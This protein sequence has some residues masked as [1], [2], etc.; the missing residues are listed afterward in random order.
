MVQYFQYHLNDYDEHV[1]HQDLKDLVVMFLY[2]VLQ[3][4][5]DLQIPFFIK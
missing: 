1:Q 4:L 5:L 3:H 2:L